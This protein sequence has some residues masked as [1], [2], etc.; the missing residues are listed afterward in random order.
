MFLRTHWGSP[1]CF[2]PGQLLKS[3]GWSN[4]YICSETPSVW[5]AKK[6]GF[7]RC[8]ILLTLFFFTDTLCMPSTSFPAPP[9]LSHGSGV[10]YD[11][12]ILVLILFVIIN[13]TSMGQRRKNTQ[14]ILILFLID[15]IQVHILHRRL[16]RRGDWGTPLL[17]LCHD[18][19]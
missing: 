14:P 1:C 2:L 11:P 8:L 7:S 17:L 6:S 15:K 3:S 4:I 19:Q 10:N 16:S 9:F 5:L 18:I 12:Y 13:V